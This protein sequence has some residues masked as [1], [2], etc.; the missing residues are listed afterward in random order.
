M[1]HRYFTSESTLPGH[2]DKL[3]DQISDAI[4]DTVL[5][6]DRFA[7]IAV[8]ATIT[9]GVCNIFG[10]ITAK[11]NV[12]YERIARN[13][14]R[15][16]GYVDAEIGL[17]YRTCEINVNIH[18]QSTDIAKAVLKKETGAGD[19]G[20]MYG[21]AINHT[22]VYM[23]L[24]IMLAHSIAKRLHTARLK[25]ALT[26][27][28]PDGKTQVTVELEDGIPFRIDSVV[29]AVQHGEEITKEKLKEDIIKY[30]IVPT[31]GELLDE[32]TKIYINYS[33][34]FVLGGPA[35]DSGLTGKKTVVDSYGGWAHNGGGCFS[36]KDPT[37]VDRS[38]AYMARFVAKNIVA[39]NL[40]DE[41]EI[42][43]AYVIGRSKPVSIS[44]D[45]RGTEHVNLSK[46]RRVINR[47]SFKP[48]DMIKLLDLRRPVYRRTAVF[49]HFGRDIFSWE[50]LK[51]T[52][53]KV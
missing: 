24:P 5:K 8:D 14:I 20:I 27:L 53:F 1:G 45:T 11:A 29:V 2:P 3:C 4:V 39:M 21:Y 36:G 47:F 48:D 40:A 38:A 32:S 44:F 46:I 12:D 10:E 50:K 13:V 6:K 23:P 33:G 26:Y 41:I 37:K 52:K 49:G 19:Q 34:R 9:R 22:D 28:R 30:V 15:D 7:R 35:A 17:D 31:V 18:E 42:S 16:V 25:N 43:V 51:P